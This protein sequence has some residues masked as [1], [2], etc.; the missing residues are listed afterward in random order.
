MVNLRKE[1]DI[2]SLKRLIDKKETAAEADSKFEQQTGQ[3]KQLDQNVVLIAQDFDKFQRVITRINR[4][5]HDLQEINKDVLLGK[6]NSNC[7]SCTKKDPHDKSK[8]LQG[9]DGK[10][11]FGTGGS[12]SRQNHPGST[13]EATRMVVDLN[14]KSNSQLN[15]PVNAHSAVN[16][17]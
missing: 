11:Y 6:K 3:L 4:S 8:N 13:S 10:F 12:K 7:L 15:S 17:S 9:L 16:I 5:L 14:I 1:F 2:N